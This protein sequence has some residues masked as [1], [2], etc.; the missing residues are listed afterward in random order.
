MKKSFIFICIGLIVSY[1]TSRVILKNN[2]E[3]LLNPTSIEIVIIC[4]FFYL[5][6][7]IFRGIRIYILS[8]NDKKSLISC[9]YL[10]LKVTSF[11]LILPFRLGDL[12][13]I[14]IFRKYL[15]GISESVTI[16]AAEKIFD[17]LAAFSIF[18]I[19]MIPDKFFFIEKIFENIYL[20]IFTISLI[21]IGLICIF[22]IYY[23]FENII[24]KKIYQ[25]KLLKIIYHI[26]FVQK[27]II[28]ISKNKIYHLITIT[29]LIWFFDS[30]SFIFII[31]IIKSFKDILL[32]GPIVA[33]SSILPSPP[34]GLSGSVPIGL[35]WIQFIT[36]IE[37]LLKYSANYSLYIYGSTIIITIIIYFS[38]LTLGKI[39]N[40][41]IDIK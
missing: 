25:S 10:Q 17:L 9:I 28:I 13:R 34:L 30:L 11:Q 33:L 41:F 12:V 16:F 37:G 35:Y 26:I 22:F 1:F 4:I 8:N 14:Y 7:L 31:P 18:F 20:I 32:I 24:S 23:Y 40:N 39:K 2:F 27:K 19:W 5:V 15:N 21:L 29:Y 38:R 36:G 6:S 3:F